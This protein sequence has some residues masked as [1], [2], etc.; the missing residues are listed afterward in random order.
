[1]LC[2]DSP[3]LITFIC[4]GILSRNSSTWLIIPTLR[5]DL[6]CKSRRV[7]TAICRASPLKDPNPS[8][9]KRMSTEKSLPISLS[10]SARDN[11]TRKLSPPDMV[12]ALRRV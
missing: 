11:E 5:P 6:E 7:E 9:M 1:M 10:A 2:V 12:E 3:S 8:S 4:V